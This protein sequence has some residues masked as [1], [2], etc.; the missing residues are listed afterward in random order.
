LI[1]TIGLLPDGMESGIHGVALDPGFHGVPPGRAGR[2][3]DADG[4][5]V[6]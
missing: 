6:T 2:D 5:G 4:A 3:R 1:M